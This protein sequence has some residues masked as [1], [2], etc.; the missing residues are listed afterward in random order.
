VSATGAD[1]AGALAI[2]ALTSAAAFGPALVD[3]LSDHPSPAECEALLERYVELKERTVSDK[4]DAKRREADHAGHARRSGLHTARQPRG[5]S[6]ALSPVNSR[7]HGA[8]V[9]VLES[10]PA[11]TP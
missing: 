7:G 5:R 3:R 6:R 8:R 11:D 9:V 2:V 4:V 10:H 1:L